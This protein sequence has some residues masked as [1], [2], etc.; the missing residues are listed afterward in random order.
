[1]GGYGDALAL[2][3]QEQL[4]Q[5]QA[6]ANSRLYNADGSGK[7]NDF[8]PPALPESAFPPSVAGGT[9]LSVNTDQ[10]QTI[11]AQMHGDLAQLQA[12]LQTL[13]NGG[14][15]G[16]LLGGGWPTA[17]ALGSTAGNAYWG[18]SQFYQDLNHAY[19]MVIGYMRQSASNYADAETT[20]ASAARTVGSETT[21]G[22]ALG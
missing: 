1:M 22:G 14:V 3:Q 2:E 7:A 19:D 9:E 16:E 15:L 8:T 20:T 6:A 17:E 13:N 11:A 10:L 5:Q 21:P 12:T 4:D 18:I